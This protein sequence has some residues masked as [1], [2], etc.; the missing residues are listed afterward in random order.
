MDKDTS[1]KANNSAD[2][3]VIWKRLFLA[4]A[5]VLVGVL[6]ASL[7]LPHPLT[8]RPVTTNLTGVLLTLGSLLAGLVVWWSLL[9]QKFSPQ[10]RT[11]VEVLI[12]LTAINIVVKFTG[13]L[14]SYFTFLYFLPILYSAS[15]FTARY[16][17]AVFIFT[18]LIMSFH[19]LDNNGSSFS[20]SVSALILNL[21]GVWLVNGLGRS[22]A[23]QL[24][25]IHQRQVEIQLEQLNKLDKIK[26]EFVF[27]IA[28]ELRSPITAIRGYLELITTD[29]ALKIS[30]SLKSLLQKSFNTSTKLANLVGLLLEIARIETGKIR[31]YYQK[32]DLR[33]SLDFVTAALRSEAA[34]KDIQI[35]TQVEKE[36]IVSVDKERLEE[37]LNIIIGNAIEYTR[38]HGKILISSQST[39]KE[40]I[41]SISDT[42]VGIAPDKKDKIFEKISSDDDQNGEATV[43][44]YRISLYVARQL[45]ALMKGDITCESVVGRGTTFNLSLPRYWSWGTP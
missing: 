1:G 11:F 13:G 34:Q 36:N 7:P 26:D 37:I 21:F 6:V 32:I 43:K 35:T 42:G 4:T 28:H 10:V 20:G 40:I 15:N 29:S 2:K 17:W 45:L 25:L 8:S 14:Y 12:Y 16:S 18:A 38:E 5:L 3:T 41:L 44:E 19:L 24:E 23:E 30:E 27:I 39:E 9:A 31:F 22:L 33:D